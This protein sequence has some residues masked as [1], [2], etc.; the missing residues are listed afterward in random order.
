MMTVC[1]TQ[2]G[3]SPGTR[4]ARRRVEFIGGGTEYFWCTR[5]R[6]T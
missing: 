3:N 4:L 6:K 2:A 5:P 1:H